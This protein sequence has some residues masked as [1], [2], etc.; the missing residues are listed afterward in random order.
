MKVS[1]ILEH[2]KDK[3]KYGHYMI[4]YFNYLDSEYKDIADYDKERKNQGLPNLISIMGEYGIKE[5]S[6][7]DNIESNKSASNTVEFVGSGKDIV[8]LMKK[9][10]CDFKNI[11]IE[12]A[13]LTSHT[14][15][16]DEGTAVLSLLINIPDEKKMGKHI[17]YSL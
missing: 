7:T 15:S 17:L 3:W 8:D 16:I 1:K 2:I 14:K 12:E 11:Y 10:L 13:V 9:A 6:I 4:I 5:E